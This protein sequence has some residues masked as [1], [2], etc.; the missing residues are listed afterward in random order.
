M[1]DMQIHKRLT[2]VFR[3]V[4]EDLSLE[5]KDESNAK[6]IPGWDSLAHVNLTIAIEEEFDIRFL[7]TEIASFT[8]VGDVKKVIQER[9]KV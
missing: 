5:I 7:T 4:F 8:C 3:E 6:D 9:I 1:L 2:K